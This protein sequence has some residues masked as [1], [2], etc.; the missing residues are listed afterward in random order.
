MLAPM[1]SPAGEGGDERDVIAARSGDRAAF[2]RLHQRFAPTVHAVLLSRLS[3]A[4]ADDL[5]Q[6][7]FLAAMRRLGDLREPGAFASWLLT[8]A[9]NAAA[10]RSRA[11][12]PA[13]IPGECAAREP[14]LKPEAAEALAAIRS[15]PEAFRETLLMRLVEGLTGP[16]IAART[17]MTHGSVRVNLHRG[18]AMLRERLGVLSSVKDRA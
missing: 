5:T 16:E 15:L 8:I 1:P 9:R 6:E 12:R 13:E 18:M 7:V 14:G 11:P 17:G 4:D 10:S 3:S 2:A